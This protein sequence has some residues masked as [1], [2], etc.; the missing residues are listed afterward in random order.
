MLNEIINNIQNCSL[1]KEDDQLLY[2]SFFKNNNN[3][4][5]FS[6]Q[7][8][9]QITQN[10][11]K[12]IKYYDKEKGHLITIAPDWG[13][14]IPDHIYLP[15]GENAIDDIPR[16]ASNLLN[17]IKT[18]IIIKKIYG[19]KDKEYL[20]KN[21]FQE[22]P[23][24]ITLE[25][26]DK[27][28]EIISNIDF[29]IDSAEN[30]DKTFDMRYY[31]RRIANVFKKIDGEEWVISEKKLNKSIANDFKTIVDKWSTDYILR[32]SNRSLD[33]KLTKDNVSMVYYPQ[34]LSIADDQIF[35][36]IT[37]INLQ[38]VA[39]TSAYKISDNCLA[40]NGSL[41]D[42]SYKGLIQF[43]YYQLARKAKTSGYKFLNL[44][45][46]DSKSQDQYKCRMGVVTKN[47]PFSFIYYN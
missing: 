47:Q 4:Y 14:S 7:F 22:T 21:G 27:F 3:Y 12:G 6:W 17:I 41:C 30:N 28:P 40:V 24:S 13:E 20:F 18:P 43:L 31:K 9:K 46:N 15:L 10:Y 44:G 39:F 32:S 25:G 33:F 23:L 26:D 37:Y 2:Q 19:E 35:C 36:Y 38:P 42:T 29:L 16:L 8:I 45:S 34:F 5:P 1:I 11:S